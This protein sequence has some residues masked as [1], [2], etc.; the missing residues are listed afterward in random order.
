M[1]EYWS[2]LHQQLF[3]IKTK[4]R[5]AGKNIQISITRG[6]SVRIVR[7]TK[8]CGIMK[9]TRPRKRQS[10]FLARFFVR[11]FGWSKMLSFSGPTTSSGGGKRWPRL[12]PSCHWA[13]GPGADW[14]APTNNTKGP[15][16]EVPAFAA[17]Q[18][19]WKTI[20]GKTQIVKLIIST[21]DKDY[22][23][24]VIGI[25]YRDYSWVHLTRLS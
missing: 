6:L 2:K 3:L 14:V 18:K 9:H 20:L 17:H 16:K 7:Q 8:T 19:K 22:K 21:S 23:I 13:S 5:F 24:W 12:Y 4:P 25:S 1:W 11:F 15:A 10:L